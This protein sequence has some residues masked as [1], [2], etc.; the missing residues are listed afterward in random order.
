MAGLRVEEGLYR[1]TTITSQSNINIDMAV[2]RVAGEVDQTERKS[3]EVN[4][5]VLTVDE[6]IAYEL[7]V[8]SVD[9]VV[10]PVL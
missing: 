7:Q 5:P 3:V 6:D 10:I 4:W 9:F 2:L 1:R 8:S